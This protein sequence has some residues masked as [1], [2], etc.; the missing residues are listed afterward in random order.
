MIELSGYEADVLRGWLGEIL[1]TNQPDSL[2]V[3]EVLE[4]IYDR[5][6]EE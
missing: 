5:L 4:R 6:L 1:E 3:V 2:R